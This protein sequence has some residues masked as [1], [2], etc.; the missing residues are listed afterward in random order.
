MQRFNEEL[1]KT[2]VEMDA[3]KRGRVI[4]RTA[5]A[6]SL[7]QF[8]LTDPNEENLARAE[9]WVAWIVK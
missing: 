4:T 1:T 2:G 7:I 8:G 5:I 3:D 9:A 6:K